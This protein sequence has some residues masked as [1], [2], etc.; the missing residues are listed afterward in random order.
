[1]LGHVGVGG[2]VAAVATR[3]GGGRVV[4]A[5][6]G[7]VGGVV[8]GAGAMPGL[9]PHVGA[10]WP[11][12]GGGA[13]PVHADGGARGRAAR[14]RHPRPHHGPRAGLHQLLVLGPTVLEPDFHLKQKEAIS[15]SCN[16]CD[17]LRS[18]SLKLCVSGNL[19]GQLAVIVVRR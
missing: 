13:R 6:V 19:L 4:V 3:G 9:V 7:E 16:D 5:A 18:T 11:W 14:E 2:H 15:L 12:G 17:T 1:M 10:L 8:S